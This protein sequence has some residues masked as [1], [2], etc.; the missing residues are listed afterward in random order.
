MKISLENIIGELLYRHARVELPGFGVFEKKRSPALFSSKRSLFYPPSSKINFME[1]GAEDK[2]LLIRHISQTEN[3]VEAE[4]EKLIDE[5]IKR[6]NDL[7]VQQGKLFLKGLGEIRLVNDHKV[8]FPDFKFGLPYEQFGLGII[9]AR[10]KV[11]FPKPLE[12]N[13]KEKSRKE[14]AIQPEKT[15]PTITIEDIIS[16]QSSKKQDF[17]WGWMKYAAV[18]VLGLAMLWGVYKGY[19]RYYF[20]KAE[21]VHI[22]Q[23]TFV[24]PEVLPAVEWNASGELETVNEVE[25]KAQVYIIAGAFRNE[26]NARK[27]LRRLKQMGFKNP[28]LAGVNKRGLHLVA[29]EGFSSVAEA[30]KKLGYIKK[31]YNPQA[32]ILN[33]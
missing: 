8:F 4:V 20:K 7:L 17:S 30:Q 28:V 6:W 15:K 26:S 13:Q 14:I 27:M 25:K 16:A 10:K 12:A 21:P 2:R 11:S 3:L 9:S 24:I 23:A 18:T 32:W 29:Y 1:D 5:Q 31:H 22:Q 33:P 19:E